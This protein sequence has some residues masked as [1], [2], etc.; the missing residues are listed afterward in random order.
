[1]QSL[2]DAFKASSHPLDLQA[3]ATALPKTPST[4]TDS[5][6][7]Q[8][9]IKASQA[10]RTRSFSLQKSQVSPE[11]KLNKISAA[12][13]VAKVQSVVERITLQQFLVKNVSHAV[14]FEQLAV[15]VPE[16]KVSTKKRSLPQMHCF[17]HNNYGYTPIREPVIDEERKLATFLCGQKTV[18][19]SLDQ[20]G[21]E[22]KRV[23]IN[24]LDVI[25]A[26]S[27]LTAQHPV[28]CQTFVVADG[29]GKG[30]G[31]KRAA[32]TCASLSTK[33]IDEK[34]QL[35]AGGK[36]K[37][38]CTTR[39]IVQIHLDVLQAMQAHLTHEVRTDIEKAE[40]DSKHRREVANNHE[41][42]PPSQHVMMGTTTATYVTVVQNKAII[43][44]LG[45]CKAF[46]IRDK[47][48][49]DITAGS[50]EHA[51]DA[52]DPGGRLGV[53]NPD[54]APDWGNL[55]VHV[56][57]LKT[58]DMILACTDG[59]YDNFYP[60][61]EGFTDRIMQVV[62]DARGAAV[63]NALLKHIAEVTADKK[64]FMLQNPGQ[65]EPADT[66]GKADHASGVVFEFVEEAVKSRGSF[67]TKNK[68]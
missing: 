54:D 37:L 3:L 60:Q 36:S 5:T 44:S 9:N 29:C 21:I 4:S 8:D 49:I 33:W 59:V 56:L 32:E 48:C 40:Q 22:E 25:F 65:K 42:I 35:L 7:D 68:K 18:T 46:L 43:T 13:E 34:V 62:A 53:T 28:G 12:A 24:K 55:A 64:I 10:P 17:T 6:E 20:V 67:F 16:Y 66:K 38:K 31:P 52:T 41:A 15:A 45:D 19:L 61:L 30:L 11:L 47:K 23:F 63:G 58:S 2:S 26:D 27:V 51:K 14:A 1:M 50:R 39:S 57:E